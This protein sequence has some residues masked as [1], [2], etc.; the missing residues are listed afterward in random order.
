MLESTLRP[1]RAEEIE[2]LRGDRV[3]ERVAAAGQDHRAIVAVLADDV[4]Q[5]DELL[6]R[7][8]VEDQFDAIGVQDHLEHAV[9]LAA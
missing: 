6:V 2:A 3:H 8:A 4:K 5:L 7:V 9:G 1:S